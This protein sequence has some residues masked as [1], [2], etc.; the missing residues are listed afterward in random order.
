MNSDRP[1]IL[2]A[3]NWWRYIRPCSFDQ[4]KHLE[5][6]V[7]N[8]ISKA[9]VRLAIAVANRIRSYKCNQRKGK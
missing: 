2:A 6:P 3:I 5:M 1:V 9:E 8:T 7:I 4:K